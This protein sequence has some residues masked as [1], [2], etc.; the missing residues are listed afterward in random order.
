MSPQ[1]ARHPPRDT[2]R[3]SHH[4]RRLPLHAPRPLT[5]PR[6]QHPTRRCR[7]G[8]STRAPRAQPACIH[9]CTHRV[10]PP[11]CPHRVPHRGAPTACPTA[12]PPPRR[13]RRRARD[14]RL[15]AAVAALSRPSERPQDAHDERGCRDGCSADARGAHVACIHAC[16]HG[17][18]GRPGRSGRVRL[19]G[20]RRCGRLGAAGLDRRGGLAERP[21]A[22][23]LKTVRAGPLVLKGS[24][25]LP[26]AD[27]C[28]CRSEPV[29]ESR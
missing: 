18:T 22:T 8:C 5:A 17:A 11:R 29:S 19:G 6:A 27:R 4:P 2:P 20:G 25:P 13:S 9:T 21:K 12:V 24:N 16:T 1:V 23:V 7:Y 3:R 28:L 10:A 14:A 15:S 26:S